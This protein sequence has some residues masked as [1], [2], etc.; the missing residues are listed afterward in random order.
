MKKEIKSILEKYLKD[1]EVKDLDVSKGMIL[2]GVTSSR[3]KDVDKV[4]ICKAVK[5]CTTK[6]QLTSYVY[7]SILAYNG[8]RVR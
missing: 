6:L 4:K 2:K 1:V 8:L 7:N 5:N 3:I